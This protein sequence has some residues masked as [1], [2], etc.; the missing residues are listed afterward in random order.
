MR[1]TLLTLGATA[2][3]AAGALVLTAGA[4]PDGSGSQIVDGADLKTAPATMPPEVGDYPSYDY[5]LVSIID[6][7]PKKYAG[8]GLKADSNEVA[9]E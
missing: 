8:V 4:S 7:W 2:A 9:V 5:Q 3:T 1:R 6:A